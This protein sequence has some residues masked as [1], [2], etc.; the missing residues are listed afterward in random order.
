MNR[1]LNFKSVEAATI[2]ISCGCKCGTG[3]FVNAES[4]TPLLL[5]ANHI[6]SESDNTDIIVEIGD[7]KVKCSIVT[8]IP[9]SDVAIILPDRLRKGI[10]GLP[11]LGDMLPY[12]AG[13][14]AFGY[15]AQR[16]DSGARFN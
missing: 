9:E 3:F 12:N 14:E 13:W 4:G 11:L 15:P 8:R 6:L 5:T 10:S 7:E 1:I 16:I 2:R